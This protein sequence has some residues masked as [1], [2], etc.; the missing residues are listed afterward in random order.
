MEVVD[1]RSPS[2]AYATG[3]HL[4]NLASGED[5]NV[6]AV[7]SRWRHCDDLTG[8]GIKPQ[9][10]RTDSR[11][12]STTELTAG[13]GP[14]IEPQT[15][16]VDSDVFK[17]LR[18]LAGLVNSK[19]LTSQAG[20]LP[21]LQPFSSKNAFCAETLSCPLIAVENN[22]FMTSQHDSSFNSVP[23]DFVQASILN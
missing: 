8:P 1:S 11:W 20:H 6:A 5:E 17:P 23:I 9:I 19:P 10:F 14:E 18:Q 7:A 12:R 16:R 13:T 22:R 21:A 4:R 2:L 15:S 3:A